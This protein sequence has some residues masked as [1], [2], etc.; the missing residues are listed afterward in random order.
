MII[1]DK[2]RERTGSL[3]LTINL[4]TMNG[5]TAHWLEHLPRRW[6]LKYFFRQTFRTAND[7][8]TLLGGVV[9]SIWYLLISKGGEGVDPVSFQWTLFKEKR[10]KKSLFYS[11][12]SFTDRLETSE[13]HDSMILF[14]FSN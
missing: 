3:E 2:E 13:F 12:K 14:T 1:S 10:S 7:P 6:G 9:K 11:A 8:V 5:F 4:P